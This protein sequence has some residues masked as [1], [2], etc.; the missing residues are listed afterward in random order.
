MPSLK[1]INQNPATGFQLVLKTNHT[2]PQ[3]GPLII[4]IDGEEEKYEVVLDASCFPYTYKLTP[5]LIQ[6]LFDNGK[7]YSILCREQLRCNI[8][9]SQLKQLLGFICFDNIPKQ[10]GPI[11]P[12]QFSILH[13]PP[14]FFC[15]RLGTPYDNTTSNFG[16]G[17]LKVEA[18]IDMFKKIIQSEFRNGNI[19]QLWFEFV[20][21]LVRIGYFN[22]FD[23]ND[24]R[25]FSFLFF[26]KMFPLGNHIR[27]NKRLNMFYSFVEHLMI[28]NRCFIIFGQNIRPVRGILSRQIIE[29]FSQQLN[30]V[31][32]FYHAESK[33][34][35]ITVLKDPVHT[36]T[37]HL[38][39]LTRMEVIDIGSFFD[40]KNH[41]QDK[42]DYIIK[43]ITKYNPDDD[44]MEEVVLLQRTA[45]CGNDISFIQ[46]RIIEIGG[47]NIIAFNTRILDSKIS[48]YF[49]EKKNGTIEAFPSFFL[50]LLHIFCPDKRYLQLGDHFDGSIDQIV[51]GIL[52]CG[53]APIFDGTAT[54]DELRHFLME[55]N[56]GIILRI[57][58]S[59]YETHKSTL[60]AGSLKSIRE[61]THFKNFK[62][63]LEMISRLLRERKNSELSPEIH[64][65]LQFM[66]VMI[67]L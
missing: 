23:Y 19:Q 4:T 1:S 24:F 37:C 33:C 39:F 3:N 5:V 52:Q 11:G 64:E 41:L 50:T 15:I 56:F 53:F 17:Y 12:I 34:V 10:L 26:L 38:F 2:T 31:V 36:S 7:L 8:K 60:C 61:T 45:A 16:I 55:S 63:V 57:M 51:K 47:Y 46:N 43:H 42:K 58:R 40:L 66:D 20:H 9:S 21:F 25:S 65:L 6:E 13:F 67:Q 54:P 35:G 48:S 62:R 59:E 18:V 28:W 27:I 44:E 49:L 32:N 14:E 29:L 30:P 22:I